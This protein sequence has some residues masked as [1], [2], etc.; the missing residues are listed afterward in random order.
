MIWTD[1]TKFIA[2]RARS[3]LCTRR[4]RRR[5]ARRPSAS[6]VAGILDGRGATNALRKH[7]HDINSASSPKGG[8]SLLPKLNR[9]TAPSEHCWGELVNGVRASR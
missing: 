1:C 7:E 8:E 9:L 5:R 2:I 4:A 6:L 3:G